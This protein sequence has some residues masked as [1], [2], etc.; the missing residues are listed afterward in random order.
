LYALVLLHFYSAAKDELSIVL[1][2]FFAC[3]FCF[4][5][6]LYKQLT[7]AAQSSPLV[8]RLA[9]IQNKYTRNNNINNNNS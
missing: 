6:F 2:C 3:L 5:F 7:D 9:G 4:D 8:T 1:Y